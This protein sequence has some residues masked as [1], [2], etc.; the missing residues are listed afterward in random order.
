M[1]AVDLVY[2]PAK[3]FV[4]DCR[5]VLKKCSLPSIKIIKK[6]A[7]S[8]AAGFVVLGTIGF[9]FKLVSIPINNVIIGS[10]VNK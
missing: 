8:T 10:M 1:E 5:R 7:L 3:R 6:T 2:V 9:V 4:D